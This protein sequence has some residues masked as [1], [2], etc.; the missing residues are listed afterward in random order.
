MKPLIPDLSINWQ[1]PSP[2]PV[3]GRVFEILVFVLCRLLA[4]IP[5]VDTLTRV[6]N[7]N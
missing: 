5:L 3:A 7:A 2:I 6:T 1:S 4:G